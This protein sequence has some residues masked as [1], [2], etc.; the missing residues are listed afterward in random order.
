MHQ[1]RKP[2]RPV[3]KLIRQFEINE[4]LQVEFDRSGVLDV[5]I[6]AGAKSDSS[7]SSLDGSKALAHMA[8]SGK[9]MALLIQDYVS[10]PGTRVI[11]FIFGDVEVVNDGSSIRIF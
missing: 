8:P 4:Q 1:S 11:P 3:L 10:A 9:L 7:L 5:I 6:D 2:G